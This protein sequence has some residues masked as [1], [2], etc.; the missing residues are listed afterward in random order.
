[1][2]HQLIVQASGHGRGLRSLV[3]TTQPPVSYCSS[4]E[5]ARSR[6][7]AAVQ[8]RIARLPRSAGGFEP[9]TSWVRARCSTS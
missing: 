1:M 2:A 6:S 4:K 7:P 5:K 8:R 9:Q 3:V